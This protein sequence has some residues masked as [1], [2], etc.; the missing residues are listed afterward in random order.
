MSV[1]EGFGA[2]F[3]H[4]FLTEGLLAALAPDDEG[5]LEMV[6]VSTNWLVLVEIIG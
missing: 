3:D 5:V 6:E 2:M 4:T 1:R